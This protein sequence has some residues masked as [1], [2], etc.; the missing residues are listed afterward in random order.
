MNILHGR[1]E[2]RRV[3]PIVWGPTNVD[4]PTKYRPYLR[5]YPRVTPQ[6]VL[7]PVSVIGKSVYRTYETFGPL[8][9][10]NRGLKR[11]DYTLEC[12]I[13]FI[14]NRPS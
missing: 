3:Q 6:Y 9:G 1:R 13:R 12:N 10:N 11:G 5:D 7:I 4:V 2:L 14:L 8:V